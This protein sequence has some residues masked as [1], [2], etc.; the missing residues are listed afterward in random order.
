MKRLVRP[1]TP[2]DA[3]AI[4]A[5]FAEVGL[6]PSTDPRHLQWKYWQPRADWPGPRSF[7]LMSGGEL[8][9]HAA[10]IPGS[11]AWGAHQL[12]MIHVIDWMARRGEMGAGG[13][14][15]RHIGG[16]AGALLAIGG[17]AVTLRILP[18]MGFRPAGSATGYV[19]TL[20]PLRRLVGAGNPAWKL[21]PRFARSVAWTLA[22]PSARSS[23]WQARHLGSDEIS[24]IASVLPRPAPGMTVTGRS[25]ELFRYML[26]CP[27]VPIALFAVERA[28]RVRGY[29]VL[30]S[31][32]GQVRIADC[33]MS[34]DE[35]S[36]WRA[37]I[38][39]AVEQAR[40]DPQAAEAVIWASDPVLAGALQ[41]CG[42]HARREFPIQ[43]RSSDVASTSAA[44][45]R[46]QML[47][48]DAAFLHEGR[49]DYWA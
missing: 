8:I 3:P 12:P 18:H 21:L 25:V 9:A 2:A 11:C 13:T 17:S 33:W 28:G 20:F 6:Q 1:S 40:H 34:S 39:C 49:N 36:D 26:A 44:P 4:V 37:M 16:L 43:I 23:E 46:V 15:M 38:L 24:H 32:P 22:A 41:A 48:N 35:P 29:F 19:R 27:I 42:F 47:D 7:V 30:A 10:L 45:L 31:T 5:L 14:L